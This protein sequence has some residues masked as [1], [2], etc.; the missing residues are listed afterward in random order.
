MPYIG[1]ILSASR[2]KPDPAKV[3][4]IKDWHLHQSVK[5]LKSF[6]GSANYMSRFISR[7]SELREP[8]QQLVKKNTEFVGMDHHTKAFNSIKDTI[9]ADCLV[10]FFDQT[11]PLSIE[12]DA[13]LQDIHSI[14][15]QSELHLHPDG[16]EIPL[17]LRPITFRSKS[18]SETEKQ[19]SNIEQESLDIVF[20]VLH[21]KHYVYDHSITVISDHKPLSTLFQKSLQST[22]PKLTD[23]A[24]Q[25]S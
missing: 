25:Y 7:L 23:L 22:A 17:D 24:T 20:C 13:S 4:V 6:L 14:L 19:Y 12:S 18:L 5:E 8:L 21:F 9:S 15:L 10:H 3:H 11:K 1:T 2:I 16:L